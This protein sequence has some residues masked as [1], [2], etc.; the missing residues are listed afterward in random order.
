MKFKLAGESTP[1]PVEVTVTLDDEGWPELRLNG[2]MI[3]FI[4]SDGKV[5]LVNQGTD[6]IETLEKMGMQMDG[7]HVFA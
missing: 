3:L 6:R 7:P 2:I 1:Q 4:T 5:D